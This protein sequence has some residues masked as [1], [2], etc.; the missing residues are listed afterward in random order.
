MMELTASLFTVEILT[1]EFSSDFR[2]LDFWRYEG[3]I[4]LLHHI[5]QY[6]MLMAKDTLSNKVVSDIQL[7]ARQTRL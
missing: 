7:H 6:G 2:M 4:D 5:Q 3:K 1:E